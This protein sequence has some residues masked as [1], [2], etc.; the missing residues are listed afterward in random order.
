MACRNPTHS[1]DSSRALGSRRGM[2]VRLA[3]TG[4]AGRG[5][6]S[7][8]SPDS[9]QPPVGSAVAGGVGAQNKA[10]VY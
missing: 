7:R 3:F 1:W 4:W 2:G 9:H 5:A 8:Q 6:P 10:G